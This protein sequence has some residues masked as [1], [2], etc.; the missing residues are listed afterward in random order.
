MSKQFSFMLIFCNVN[1]IESIKKTLT[2]VQ[3]KSINIIPCERLFFTQTLVLLHFYSCLFLFFFIKC[4]FEFI[5]SG[6]I[7]FSLVLKNISLKLQRN[8]SSFILLSKWS[9]LFFIILW[10]TLLLHK[11]ND[12]DIQIFV[13]SLSKNTDELLHKIYI[14]T[15]LNNVLS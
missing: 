5:C 7:F 1:R 14:F 10:K 4:P 13:I 12:L 6:E 11:F 3:W 8:C 2:I 9:L 15:Y